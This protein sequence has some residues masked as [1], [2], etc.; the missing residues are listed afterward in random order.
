[1]SKVCITPLEELVFS[2][3]LHD[4]GLLIFPKKQAIA[5]LDEHKISYTLIK[6][7]RGDFVKE[8]MWG[9]FQINEEIPDWT[10]I[11]DKTRFEW[12]WNFNWFSPM[13]GF[14]EHKWYESYDLGD[15]MY[16]TPI[17]AILIERIVRKH[18]REINDSFIIQYKKEC[19][20][21]IKSKK[22]D[23]MTKVNRKYTK[24]RLNEIISILEGFKGRFIYVNN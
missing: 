2:S 16:G 8:V 22:H 24:R 11:Y 20:K 3:I 14:L 7:E 5:Y 10:E 9:F 21:E 6:E 19:K 15:D 4:D 18:G 1:M 13:Y 12:V 17:E 23:K